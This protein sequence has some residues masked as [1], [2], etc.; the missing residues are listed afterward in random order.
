[1]DIHFGRRN[2]RFIDQRLRAGSQWRYGK[3]GNSICGRSPDAK[4]GVHDDPLV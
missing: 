4:M 2:V 3:H 1:L